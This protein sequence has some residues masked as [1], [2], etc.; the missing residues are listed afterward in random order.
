M[1]TLRLRAVHFCL[2]TVTLCCHLIVAAPTLCADDAWYAIPFDELEITEGNILPA[3]DRRAINSQAA[4]SFRPRFLLDGPGTILAG[5]QVG[6]VHNHGFANP[7]RDIRHEE[8]SIV[9]Q[10][11]SGADITGRMWLPKKDYSGMYEIKFRIPKKLANEKHRDKFLATQHFWYQTLLNYRVAGQAWFRHQALGTA[12]QRGIRPEKSLPQDRTRFHTNGILLGTKSISNSLALDQLLDRPTDEPN[13]IDPQTIAGFP[14]TEL[15]WNKIPNENEFVPD[16]LAD[17]IPFDQ[18]AIF[19]SSF[20]DYIDLVTEL[21]TNGAPFLDSISPSIEDSR[22]LSLY[23]TQLCLSLGDMAKSIDNQLVKSMAFTGTDPYLRGGSEVAVLLQTQTPDMLTIAVKTMQ[24]QALRSVDGCRQSEGKI[25]GITWTAV[26]SPARQ[27]SSYVMQTDNTVII[28]NSLRQLKQLSSA[29]AGAMPA[30]ESLPEYKHFRSRYRRDNEDETAFLMLSGAA[31]RQWRSA[32]DRIASTRRTYAAAV[33]ADETARRMDDLVNGIEEPQTLTP[34][35][36]VPGMGP[37][38]LTSQGI[39]D[40]TYGSNGFLTPVSELRR[41][42]VSKSEVLAFEKWKNGH[43]Q[44]WKKPLHGLGL[45]LC[46]GQNNVAADVTVMPPVLSFN[47]GLL[48]TFSKKEPFASDTGQRHPD[49]IFHFAMNLPTVFEYIMG[50]NFSAHYETAMEGPVTLY[51]DRDPFWEEAAKQNYISDAMFNEPHRVPLA[52]SVGVTNAKKLTNELKLHE[53]RGF[54]ALTEHKHRGH[55]W[56]HRTPTAIG[57]KKYF[58]A[59][60]YVSNVVILPDSMHVS[61]NPKMI[62][63]AI[64]RYVDRQ[65]LAEKGKPI[66]DNEPKWI[67]SNMGLQIRPPTDVIDG[68][69]QLHLARR[70]RGQSWSNLWILNEWK[71]RYPKHDAVALHERIWKSRLRCPGGGSYVWNE[72]FR[73]YESTAFGHPGQPRTPKELKSFNVYHNIKHGNFGVTME[74]QGLRARVEIQR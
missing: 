5:R 67:G 23:E 43:Q 72:E 14:V 65:Q 73:T 11:A 66:L 30:I 27:I 36:R 40:A 58:G 15:D 45:R 20:Q 59:L 48:L 53:N 60:D 69:T 46:V 17:N 41:N 71:S 61:P 64:D 68:F 31:V 44:Y 39:T 57:R 12:L 47:Y 34:R 3:P 35:Y 9:A 4:L 26:V 54:I 50:P 1:P 52:I 8:N 55:T 70:L 32:A 56:Y 63:A 21:E 37:V 24:Q 42:F 6:M 33:L 19:F 62:E 13:D 7:I 38:T 18:Y 22:T 25:G 10:A 28:A 49:S 16:P 51:L 74:E 2:T 29:K